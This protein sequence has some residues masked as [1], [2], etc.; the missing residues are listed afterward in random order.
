MRKLPHFEKIS[1][2]NFG[3]HV[4]PGI[5]TWRGCKSLGEFKH[6]VMLRESDV[7]FI[8]NECGGEGWPKSRQKP[9]RQS[10]PGGPIV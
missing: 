3:R 8:Y 2:S 1:R 5:C 10:R 7:E 9:Q 6:F 4:I